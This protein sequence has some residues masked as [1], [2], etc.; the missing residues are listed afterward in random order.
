MEAIE[1]STKTAIIWEELSNVDILYFVAREFTHLATSVS[2]YSFL[3][4]S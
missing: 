3:L 4:L 1:T 2:Y